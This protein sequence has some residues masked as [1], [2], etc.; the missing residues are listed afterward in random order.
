V[1]FREIDRNQPTL[2]LDES[3]TL[4]PNHGG[5][6]DDRREPTRAL[7]N[8]GFKRGATVA[9]CVGADFD[10]QHFKVFCPKAFAGIGALP[11]TVADRSIPIWLTRK[12]RADKV[13]RLRDREA[14]NLAKPIADALQAWSGCKAVIETLSNARPGNIPEKLS[15]RQMDICEPLLAIADLAGGEW[16]ERAREALAVLCGADQ[17][18]A[19]LSTKLLLDIRRIFDARAV[20]RIVTEQLLEELI[21]MES[22]APWAIWWEADVKAGRLRGPAMRVASMLKGYRINVSS[23]ESIKPRV[24]KMPDG[25]TPRGYLRADFQDA[26]RR[27]CPLF[28]PEVAT[29][30]T[31]PVTNSE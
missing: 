22:D 12:S 28:P 30:A 7:L 15:D 25:S 31:F 20:D 21:E 3:D 18:K 6:S 13:E 14:A 2:L 11:D 1:L 24:I 26:W 4:F 17:E 23:P 19:N 27:Y 16:P 10:L 9:R 8:A 5:G 29:V